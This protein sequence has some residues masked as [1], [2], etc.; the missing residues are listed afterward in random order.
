MMHASLYSTCHF[1]LGSVIS[2]LLPKE[3]SVDH[4]W[5]RAMDSQGVNLP[6]WSDS[7]CMLLTPGGHSGERDLRPLTISSQRR[8]PHS[9]R[10]AQGGRRATVNGDDAG[11]SRHMFDGSN[12]QQNISAHYVPSCFTRLPMWRRQDRLNASLLW[13]A[14]TMA[15]FH[16]L[17][18]SR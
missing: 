5:L 7:L 14:C 8:L 1:A 18:S 4:R 15:S 9:P 16:C 13:S 6:L 17:S 3:M 2:R 11:D 10:D 12:T